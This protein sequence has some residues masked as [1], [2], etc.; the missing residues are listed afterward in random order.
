M[1]NFRS[2]EG[3]QEQVVLLVSERRLN[4]RKLGEF[5]IGSMP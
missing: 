3:S 1:R 5:Q 2:A 4:L